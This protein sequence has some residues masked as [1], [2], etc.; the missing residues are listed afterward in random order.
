MTEQLQRTNTRQTGPELLRCI[1]MMM[2]TVLHF[3]GKGNLLGNLESADMGAV[4]VSAWLLEAFC[5]V[6]VNCYMLISGYFLW[7]SEFRLEKLI[8]VLIQVW[9]YS[10]VLG[11]VAYFAGLVEAS[12]KG[13]HYFLM[14][15]F[16]ISMG[17]YWFMTAYVFL[18]LLLPFV[19]RAVREMSEKQL[20][21]SL[22]LLLI[23]FCVLKSVLPVR[24]ELDQKGYDCLWYLCMFLTGAYAAR[25]GLP[26]VKTKTHAMLTYLAGVL[27]I[28]GG[29]MCLHTVYLK[30]GSLRLLLKVFYEYNHILPFLAAAGLFAFFLKVECK[31]KFAAFLVKVS[32]YVLGAYLIQENIGLRY[33][34]QALFGAEKITTVPGLIIGSL[35]A[36]LCMLIVGIAAER[37]RVLCV[38]ALWRL[39]PRKERVHE[40]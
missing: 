3:L 39:F 32:P 31:G 26:F 8:K 21:T 11:L 17:H 38:D 24:L 18:F 29:T 19:G 25:F 14:L 1:A 10:V 40:S 9:T 16:P 2:V 27:L 13:L 15:I 20:R 5:I 30:T 12:E 34:W 7:K 6:A 35:M 22:I 23:A 36:A 4:G 28:F 33:K 37:V